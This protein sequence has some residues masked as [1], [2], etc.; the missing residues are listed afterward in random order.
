MF[1]DPKP[2]PEDF[3]IGR[4]VYR[5]PVTG[6]LSPAIVHRQSTINNKLAPKPAPKPSAKPNPNPYRIEFYFSVLPFVREATHLELR[7][8]LYCAGNSAPW[9]LGLPRYYRARAPAATA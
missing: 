9:L 8:A 6:P 1:C 2:S 7:H 3:K 5:E 4:V